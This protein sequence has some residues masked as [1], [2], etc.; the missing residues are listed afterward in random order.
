MSDW[1]DRLTRGR[2]KTPPR[3]GIYG[4]HAIGK[5]TLA[6]RFPNPIFIS[7]EDG[8]D[9]IDLNAAFPRARAYEDVLQSLGK[10]AKEPHDFKTVVLDTADWLVEPLI[11]RYVEGKHEP[12][13]LAYGKGAVLIAEEFRNVLTGFDAL[14]R[15]RGM[16]IVIIA[17]AEIR[18]FENPMTEPYDTYRPKLPVRCNALLQEWL[19]V[20]AFASF[21]VIVKNT[22]VGFNNKVR[23]GVGT[24]DRLLHLVETPA[25]VAK[26]RYDFE[27]SEVEMTFEN[28]AKFIPIAG[29]ERAQ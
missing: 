29:L 23:R 12:K 24:G 25:Y 4:G 6:N 26:N 19:D 8:L 14:R 15:K 1:Q 27:D 10:L 3:I 22:D 13:D 9:A 21:K 5:S 7:T 16:N 20:L 18:R 11:T 28:L 17:H 2:Q